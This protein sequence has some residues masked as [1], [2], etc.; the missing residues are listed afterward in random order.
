M[1]YEGIAQQI[2]QVEDR[3]WKHEDADAV[4]PVLEILSDLVQACIGVGGNNDLVFA[5]PAQQPGCQ[6]GQREEDPNN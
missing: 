3:R 6:S 2:G 1:S 5:Q 4:E